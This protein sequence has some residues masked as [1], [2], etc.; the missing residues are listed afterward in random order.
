MKSLVSWGDLVSY[1]KQDNWYKCK[2]QYDFLVFLFIFSLHEISIKGRDR[3]K[4]EKKSSRGLIETSKSA[5]V[6][7]FECV[8]N[9]E[10]VLFLSFA[11]SKPKLIISFGY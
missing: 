4:T 3:D 2:R 11:H 8:F 10:I 6:N 7:E 9:C 5:A 1:A